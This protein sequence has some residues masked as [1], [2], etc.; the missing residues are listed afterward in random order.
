MPHTL[1]IADREDTVRDTL[2]PELTADGYDTHCASTPRALALQLENHRPNLLLLGDFDGPGASA[3]LLAALR[4][5]QDPFRGPGAETPT[6]VL[7]D[8]HGDLALLRAFEAGAD[9]YLRKPASYLELLARVRTVIGRASGARIPRV[10]RVGAL[11]IDTDAHRAAYA[12]QALHLSRLEFQLLSHLGER[13][14]RVHT[15][16]ELLRDIWGYQTPGATRTIDAHCCRLRKKLVQAG[17][18]DL[19]INHRGV[20][21]ALTGGGGNGDQAA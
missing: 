8:D 20:G 17:A 13:P 14:S 11:E 5:G 6:I 21:Y 18:V 10:R 7:A 19:V 3:R 2:A 15:K 1:L 9:D 16:N 4:T 12:G